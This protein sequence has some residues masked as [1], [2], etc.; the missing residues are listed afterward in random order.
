MY[1]VIVLLSLLYNDLKEIKKSRNLLWARVTGN[2]SLDTVLLITR[3]Y[4]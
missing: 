1:K 3:T 2:V 4:R